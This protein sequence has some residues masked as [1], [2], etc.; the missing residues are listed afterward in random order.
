MNAHTNLDACGLEELDGA[1]L[2]A[3]SGGLGGWEDLF[4]KVITAVVVCVASSTD[5]LVD[6]VKAGWAASAS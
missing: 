1:E 2:M 6:G 3:V 4:V 5:A